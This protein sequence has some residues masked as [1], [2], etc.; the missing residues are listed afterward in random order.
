[1]ENDV[2]DDS[3][4]DFWTVNGT[5]AVTRPK[6]LQGIYDDDDND[7]V[8]F[9]HLQLLNSSLP[10]TLKVTGRACKGSESIAIPVRAYYRPRGLQE[11]EA[12]R[13]RDNRHMQVVTLA[14]LHT[15]RLYPQENFLIFI[16][17]EG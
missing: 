14:G 3:S 6:T 2:K 9:T 5:R 11:D 17:V 8:S 10:S 4:E 13:F 7:D 16:S 12:S 1:M 15:G